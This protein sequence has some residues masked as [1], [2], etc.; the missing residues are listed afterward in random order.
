MA[1]EVA[2][3][4]SVVSSPHSLIDICDEIVDA[5]GLAFPG[6]VFP[7]AADGSDDT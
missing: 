6:G 1:A 4:V 3:V 7:G 5:A 2:A